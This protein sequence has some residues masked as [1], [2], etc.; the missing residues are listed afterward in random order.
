MENQDNTISGI[1]GQDLL[2]PYDLN[3]NITFD[4]SNIAPLTTGQISS[5]NNITIHPIKI[6]IKS[7]INSYSI[8]LYSNLP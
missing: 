5:L 8:K 3:S 2:N 4:W 7:I 6:N 1:L